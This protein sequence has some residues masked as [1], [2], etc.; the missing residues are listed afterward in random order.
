MLKDVVVAAS[1]GVAERR[2]P[3][4]KTIL[5]VPSLRSPDT[6][7]TSTQKLRAPAPRYSLR[8]PAFADIC[9][10]NGAIGASK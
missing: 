1:L 2:T 3:H 9:R 6:R 5:K 8:T 4:T 10:G 7:S